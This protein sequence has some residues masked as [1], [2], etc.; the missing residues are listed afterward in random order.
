[1]YLFVVLFS[2]YYVYTYIYICRIVI[3][4]NLCNISAPLCKYSFV[5]QQKDNNNKGWV[6]SVLSV[7]YANKQ[8]PKKRVNVQVLKQ[9]K[10]IYSQIEREISTYI[11]IERD[12]EIEIESQPSN[13]KQI[14]YL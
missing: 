9:M 10:S 3:K 12:R 2:I 4:V 14:S 5:I 6:L 7:C 11:Y 8:Q 1:M 13:Q